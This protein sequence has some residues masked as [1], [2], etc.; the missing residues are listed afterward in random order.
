MRIHSVTLL[1][2]L[3][4]VAS[5]VLLMEAHN[6]I[7]NEHNTGLHVTHSATKDSP[8]QVIV[9]GGF[10][11]KDKATCNISVTE[12]DRG[13]SL[14]VD[15]VRFDHVF[16]CVFMGD[17]AA[18]LRCLDNDTFYWKQ[19]GWHLSS[20]KYICEDSKV[21]LKTRV[22]RKNYPESNLKLVNS[23]LIDCKKLR[24][25]PCPAEAVKTQGLTTT[26]QVHI[27]KTIRTE[28]VKGR[29]TTHIT[30]SQTQEIIP[31]E[32][33]K[34]RTTA[35][36]TPSQTEEIIPKESV[37]I[38]EITTSSS[39]QKQTTV[40][41]RANCVTASGIQPRK[42]SQQSDQQREEYEQEVEQQVPL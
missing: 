38:Q 11:T 39:V 13:I 28:Q 40:T 33:V 5:Q 26:E 36:I 1:F 42:T 2:L 15:C 16:S 21:I 23:T 24:Q 4:L 27:G 8:P 25:G 9:T 12:R 32:Q 35:H 18:C 7:K 34:G 22:C 19:I 6:E 30:P 17:P 3:L 37:K 31:T 41:T 20:Q 29:R 14:Q 10:I